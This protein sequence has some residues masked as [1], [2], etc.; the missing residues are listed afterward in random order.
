M[1]GILGRVGSN[2]DEDTQHPGAFDDAK[3][4]KDELIQAKKDR[5][6]DKG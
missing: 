4:L 3:R 2:A 5:S 6:R 1:F